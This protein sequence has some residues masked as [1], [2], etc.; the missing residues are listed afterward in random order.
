VEATTDA[1]ATDETQDAFV[2]THTRLRKLVKSLRESDT[3]SGNEGLQKEIRRA[4]KRVREN[5]KLL[6]KEAE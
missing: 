6:G 1:K 2:K 4:R 5:R 3:D